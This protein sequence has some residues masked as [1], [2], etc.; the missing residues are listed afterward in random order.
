MTIKTGLETI[1]TDNWWF[2]FAN[3]LNKNKNQSL[4]TWS[5]PLLWSESLNSRI[6]SSPANGNVEG[7][8]VCLIMSAKM[9][10]KC[11]TSPNNKISCS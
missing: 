11:S 5:S 10:W 7:L 8:I 6:K 2:D 1:R 3:E 9:D 4:S